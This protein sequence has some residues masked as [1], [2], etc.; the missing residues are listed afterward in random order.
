MIEKRQYLDTLA[1]T[2]IIFERY[3]FLK[4]NLAQVAGLEEAARDFAFRVVL[5]GGFSSGKSALLNRLAGRELFKENLGPETAVP[6][7]ICWAPMESAHAVYADGSTKQ[8][9]LEN[10]T[11]MPSDNA[12]FLSL[13][14]DNQFLKQRPELVLV[15]FP[16]FDSNVEA[17]NN[18]INAYL[19]RGSAFI[20]LVPAQN[21]TLG[22]S[23]IKFLKEASS[24][25]QSLA[26]LI[27]KS[28]L[29][30]EQKLEEIATYVQRG[31]F[32]VYG[33][34]VPVT[35]ISVK[36]GTQEDF[37]NIVGSLVD[38]F[39]PQDL[40]DL[41]LAPAINEQL[42]TGIDALARYM[43]ASKLDSRELDEK[44][45]QAKE[46]REDLVRQLE[47]ERCSLDSKYAN[48][49]IPGII[50]NLE[51]S[52]RG[53][54]DTLTEVALQGEQR[55]SDAVQG[56]VRPILADVP[57]VIQA[58]LR[59][60]I[61]HMPLIRTPGVPDDTNEATRNTLLNIVDVITTVI[62]AIGG[63]VGLP[64]G[65]KGQAGGPNVGNM[66]SGVGTGV[67]VGS[68]LNPVLGVVVG[69]APALIEIFFGSRGKQPQADPRVQVRA[70]VE[71]QA[72]P[73]IL[74]HLE[75]QITP[76]VMETRDMMFEGI[77]KKIGES[78]DA[79]T[80]AMEQ[81][82]KEKEKL[83]ADHANILAQMRS[84]MEDLQGLLIR[85]NPH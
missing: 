73:A 31:I 81:A 64:A 54:V 49:V 30:P 52:L 59:E 41:S 11:A 51:R 46:A 8:L 32:S 14:L 21:G 26:C 72:I 19:K 23:D 85:G 45:A 56:M 82:K 2:G 43:A 79:A 12:L 69:L 1:K 55:F 33:V 10:A 78:M 34:D 50:G 67:L 68:I 3:D 40:F 57:G 17:H 77:R 80:E 6:A 5:I 7:E 84:D 63:K 16:G 4:D 20:L 15:D 61:G 44:I 66:L 9:A 76:A 28:D 13:R 36:E 62:P 60:V 22:Q 75:S 27:S 71:A 39:N 70:Q 18:A 25:P 42:N 48:E 35:P 29:V 74:S 65:G 38:S 53:N 47:K 37:E 24:Y 83:A 58:N